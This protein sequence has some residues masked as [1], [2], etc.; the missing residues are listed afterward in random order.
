[1]TENLIQGEPTKSGKITYLYYDEN[2]KI[3][4]LLPQTAS[5]KGYNPVL[6]GDENISYNKFIIEET[7]DEV[8]NL[9][10]ESIDVIENKIIEQ[11]NTI[12]DEL[13]SLIKYHKIFEIYNKGNLIFSSKV[14]SLDKVKLDE[15]FF[16]IFGIKYD[17][18]NGIRLKKIN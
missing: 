6:E 13:K 15:N 17:Y 1:M 2:N 8:D 9:K 3:V 10:I 14:T 16:S 12:E 5:K 18:N 11:I 7:I 4:S